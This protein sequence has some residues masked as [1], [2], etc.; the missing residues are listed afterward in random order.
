[1][2]LVDANILL[3]AYDPGARHHEAARRWLAHAFTDEPSVGLP[4][5]MIHAFLRISTNPRLYEAPYSTAE[6]AG[7]VAGWLALQNVRAVVAG[8]RHWE[9]LAGLV[10][11][12][13]VRGPAI[14][15]AALAALA[16]EHAA[17]LYSTDRDFARFPGL[18]WKDPLE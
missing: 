18:K 11:A 1:M 15:D 10:A 17:I 13:G 6:A 16:I 5:P 14:T 8:D 7:I 4:W 9:I 12:T 3:Y 2:I